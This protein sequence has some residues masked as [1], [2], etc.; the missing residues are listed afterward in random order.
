M[1]RAL[2]IPAA[3]ALLCLSSLAWATITISTVLVGNVGNAADTRYGTHGSVGYTYNIGKYEV[4][5]GQYT[6]F[7]NAVAATDT[8]GLYCPWNESGITQNGV[9]GSYTYWVPTDF[10]NRPVSFVSYWDA[11][12]FAN[13]LHN[14]QPSGLQNTSTTEDGA[15]LTNGYNGYDGRTIQRKPGA[16]WFIPSENEW[17]KAAYYK[18]SGANYWE[19]PTKSYSINTSMANY[20]NPAGHTTSVGSYAYPSAY[21]TY[22]QGGNVWEWT[23]AIN[24]QTPGYA[25]RCMRGGSFA[26]SGDNL[27]PNYMGVTLSPCE[28]NDVGFRIVQAVPEPSS[29]MI[30]AGGLGMILGLRKRK[31]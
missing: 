22:D 16:K 20:G 31:A 11:I 24:S 12:R 19:Y 2:V 28:F 13:W 7:L 4:T 3:I 26:L 27:R 30:V 21:G 29:L 1:K 5:V 23:E 15:Y 17:Y 18:G 10:I 8:Y 9:S 25:Y 6:A 14:G